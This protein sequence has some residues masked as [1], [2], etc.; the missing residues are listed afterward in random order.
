[1]SI[2]RFGVGRCCCAPQE[3][4]AFVYG[5]ASST[6]ALDS[7]EGYIA[8]SDSWQFVQ[9]MLSI[10][11]FHSGANVSGLL[12]ACAGSGLLRTTDEYNPETDAW[13]NR[14][15]MPTP[16]RSA[17]GAEEANSLLYVFGGNDGSNPGDSIL[18]TDEYNPGGNSWTSRSDMGTPARS[19]MASF[20]IS[21]LIYSAGGETLNTTPISRDETEEYNAGSDSWSAKSALSRGIGLF[22][23]T[24]ISG[25]GYVV[26]GVETGTES[27]LNDAYEYDPSGDS[28]TAKTDL[29][30]SKKQHVAFTYNDQGYFTAGFNGSVPI[31]DNQRYDPVGDSWATVGG[32]QESRRD[33]AGAAA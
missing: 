33:C 16:G 28:W 17:T 11:I 8:A 29:N 1:M 4:V 12:Y 21:N 6:S 14:A 26:G 23:G 18:D 30:T 9:D 20:S 32:T 22:A 19:S 15:D 3:F 5:G 24:A 25:R 2:N 13:T 31:G 27:V 7:T 10:R